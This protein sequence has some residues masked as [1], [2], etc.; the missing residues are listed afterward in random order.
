MPRLEVR[1]LAHVKCG[2]NFWPAM[3]R[4]ISR[5]GLQL[6]GGRV[7]GVGTFISVFVEGLI[8]PGRRGCLEPR[9]AR[10]RRA[11]RRAELDL[12]HSLGART[13]V[14]KQDAAAELIRR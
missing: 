13:V 8:V 14:G 11:V 5:D 4:N 1:C 3:L 6:E 7:A 12:D 2:E 9:Q 10:G